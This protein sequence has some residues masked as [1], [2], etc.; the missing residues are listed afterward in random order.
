MEGEKKEKNNPRIFSAKRHNFKFLP[1]VT[2]R[3]FIGNLA[4]ITTNE[5][6]SEFLSPAGLLV[7]VE[8]QR[9]KDT[10]RSKGWG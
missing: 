2:K 7:Q 1:V 3:V 4:W 6:L 10:H 5:D 9:Y 8:I